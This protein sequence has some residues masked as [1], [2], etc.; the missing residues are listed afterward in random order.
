MGRAMTPSESQQQGLPVEGGSTVVYYD[1]AFSAGH[2]LDVQVMPTPHRH[3][4]FEIN[5]VLDGRMVYG[6]EGRRIVL[7]AGA[8]ALF[9]GMVPHQVTDRAPGTRFICIYVPGALLLDLGVGE[10][11]R[12]RLFGGGFVEA[13]RRLETDPACFRRW[14]G[15]LLSGDGRLGGIARDEIDARLRR[16]D[17]DGWTDHCRTTIADEAPETMRGRPDKVEAMT[18]FIAEHWAEP[19]RV[20]DVARAAGLHP[21]YAMTLF[22]SVVGMT[23]ADFL[24]RNRL[25]AARTLLAT[26]DR[27]MAAVAFAAGFGSVSSFYERFRARFGTS[28]AAYRRTLSPRP[29][30][31]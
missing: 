30:A 10:G 6:F 23:I 28:P 18:R 8:T 17:H 4:Q 11:L 5:H 24:D 7:E 19:L 15:D 14:H 2:L 3:T 31:P 29:H 1:H 20:A 16:L 9:S 27:D 12:R 22:H 21:N 25:D 26:S 13:D